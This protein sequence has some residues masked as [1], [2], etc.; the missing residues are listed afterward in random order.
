MCNLY[1]G[2]SIPQNK[3]RE[4]SISSLKLTRYSALFR[5]AD[6]FTPPKR[7]VTGSLAQR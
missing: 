3:A 1:F 2:T 7:T 5:C 4:E 6:I